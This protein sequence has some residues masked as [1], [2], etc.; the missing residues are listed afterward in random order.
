MVRM[1]YISIAAVV[2]IAGILAILLIHPSE[3]KRVKKQ[4]HLLSER[5]SKSQEENTFTQIQKIKEIG[6]LFDRQFELKDP[7]E[8]FSGSY[9]REEL[10]TYAGSARMHFS[11][12]D[13]IFY[14][15]HIVF[16][17]KEVAEV[18][19]TA[20]LK[21]RST[22][23]EQMDEIRELNCILKKIENK[24]LFNQVEVVEVLKK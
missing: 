22:A 12:L 3:E 7:G 10:S 2:V 5:V 9:S 6:A 16:P 15:F 21:G 18:N 8:S 4:F 11:Q 17:E 14:D 13:F 20:R 24:W 1:K 23:G 19:L